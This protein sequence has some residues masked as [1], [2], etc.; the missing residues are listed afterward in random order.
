MHL[1]VALVEIKIEIHEMSLSQNLNQ[2]CPV[3]LS[4]MIEISR[5]VPFNM[6]VESN[7]KCDQI[8]VYFS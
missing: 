5:S 7:L 6:V 2:Y 3:E 8:L 1:E 4:V